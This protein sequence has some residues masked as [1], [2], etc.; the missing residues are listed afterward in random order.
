MQVAHMTSDDLKRLEP[1]KLRQ[2]TRMKTSI[3]VSVGLNVILWSLFVFVPTNEMLGYAIVGPIVAGVLL[4][5]AFK[6]GKHLNKDLLEKKKQVI[7]GE[8][9]L[10]SR[11]QFKNSTYF[12]F[13]ISGKKYPVSSKMYNDFEEL[14]SITLERSVHGGFLLNCLKKG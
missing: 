14:E 5:I 11:T 9:Q 4:F 13:T 3:W 1:E 2:K 7:E 12:E 10:K 6:S 8:I